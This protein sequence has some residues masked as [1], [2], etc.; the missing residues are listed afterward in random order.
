MIYD[1]S[2]L[3]QAYS[4]QFLILEE[5]PKDG[6]CAVLLRKDGNYRGRRCQELCD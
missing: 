1:E 3:F 4:G 5:L 6:D 2:Y